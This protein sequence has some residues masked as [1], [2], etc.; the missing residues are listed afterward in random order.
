MSH[1]SARG[2]GPSSSLP[3]SH[4]HP[5]CRARASWRPDNLPHS[6][7]PYL[8]SYQQK[9]RCTSL[10]YMFASFVTNKTNQKSVYHLQ[11]IEFGSA[12]R[13]RSVQVK[14]KLQK[15]HLSLALTS[16]LPSLCIHPPSIQFPI[17]LINFDKKVHPIY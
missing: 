14:V 12:R 16:R 5:T 13:G 6:P 15:G 3:P 2:N 1:D 4:H 10:N 7:H 9:I 11:W 17:F 8:L